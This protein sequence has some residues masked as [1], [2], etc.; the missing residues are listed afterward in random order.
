MEALTA[1]A[2]RAYADVSSGYIFSLFFFGVGALMYHS[3]WVGVDITPILLCTAVSC[4][5]RSRVGSGKY[6]SGVHRVCFCVVRHLSL[7]TVL[8][9]SGIRP[10]TAQ[11]GAAGAAYEPT[12]N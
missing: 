10:T 3:V 12:I 6:P 7:C 2:A 5:L 8:D 11:G 4:Y 1:H 9:S